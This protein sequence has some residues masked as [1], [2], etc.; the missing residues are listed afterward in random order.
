MY[1]RSAR[2]SK[3]SDGPRLTGVLLHRKPF[4]VLKLG[5]LDA[6]GDGNAG[7]RKYCL[8]R[9]G[10]LLNEVGEIPYRGFVKRWQMVAMGFY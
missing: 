10:Q 3:R 9:S 7:G 8:Y 5:V 1:S 2:R 6:G 4:V